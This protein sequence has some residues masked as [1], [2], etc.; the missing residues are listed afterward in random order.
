MT[1]DQLSTAVKQIIDRK[2]RDKEIDAATLR[3]RE[4]QQRSNAETRTAIAWGCIFVASILG[5]AAISLGLFA[6]AARSETL[7]PN[8]YIAINMFAV[9]T[10]LVNA[11]YLAAEGYSGLTP[12]RVVIVRNLPERRWGDYTPPTQCDGSAVPCPLLGAVI[13]L[14]EE[15][16]A[17]CMIVTLAH[18][19][20][21]DAAVR[22]D[23]LRAVPTGEVRRRMEDIAA[24]VEKVFLTDTRPRCGA[25]P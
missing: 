10:A 8:D 6:K 22:M 11:G 24:A 13:R 20:A 15:Q 5:G 18:E 4:A 1:N 12:P 17:K 2:E 9:E 14:S 25:R 3:A 7:A 19:M 16:P 23:M 21:H